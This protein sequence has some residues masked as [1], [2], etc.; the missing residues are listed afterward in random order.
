MGGEG[1]EGG[2]PLQA[3]IHGGRGEGGGEAQI[4]LLGD[5]CFCQGPDICY[6]QVHQLYYRQVCQ[7][8]LVCYSLA[9]ARCARCTLCATALLLPHSQ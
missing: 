6:C 9:T 7:V 1:R 5:I 8:H 3:H 2:S 4:A